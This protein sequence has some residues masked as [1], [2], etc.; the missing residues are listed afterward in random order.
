MRHVRID[1]RHLGFELLF[2]LA[3]AKRAL[4]YL[5]QDGVDLRQRKPQRL[6]TP[7]KAHQTGMGLGVTA[8]AIGLPFWRTDEALFLVVT[9][10]VGGYPDG[11]G[12]LT[13]VHGGE[14]AGAGLQGL[15]E[16]LDIG[17]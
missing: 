14:G 11:F 17:A 2:N 9:H 3:A 10:G 1:L 7:H 15:Q 8:I 5:G 12:E 4:C 16:V 13:D 6:R